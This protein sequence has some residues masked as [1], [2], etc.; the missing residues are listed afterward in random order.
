MKVILIEDNPQ[1][2]ELLKSLLATHCP[3]VIVVGEAES[4]A[5]GA[6]LLST[7]AAD[8][9]LLDI[10]LRDGTVFDLLDRLDP[11]LFEQVGL[12]FLT[13]FSTFEYVIQ[14]LHKSAVD[15]L[16]KPVDPMQLKAAVEKVQKEISDRNLGH[17]LEE[18]RRL[19]ERPERPM[20]ALDK[21]PVQLPRGV[22]SYLNLSEIV[23]LRGEDN[24]CYL[25]TLAEKPVVSVRNLGFYKELLLQRGG[26][27]QVSKQYLVNTRFIARYDPEEETVFL[28]TGEKITA[29]RR[30]GKDLVGFFRRVFG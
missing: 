21:L 14:A 18:L 5:E 28:S 24:I 16:L 17:K 1:I 15:Y 2:R 29:S 22:F 6:V 20:D 27:V 25:H 8:L 23:Y 11:A 9:W 12:V 10:E 13:A 3:G 19:L 30:M 26:F 4:I 7:V